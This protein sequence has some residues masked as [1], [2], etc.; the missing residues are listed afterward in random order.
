MDVA[1]EAWPVLRALARMPALRELTLSCGAAV[2]PLPRP[3]DSGADGFPT[4]GQYLRAGSTPHRDFRRE[5][6]ST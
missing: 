5:F 4:G 1:G 2:P 3:A 6:I